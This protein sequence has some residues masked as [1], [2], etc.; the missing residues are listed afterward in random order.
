MRA[1]SAL[2]SAGVSRIS[3]PNAFIRT[4]GEC[5]I[6][7][8]SSKATRVVSVSGGHLSQLAVNRETRPGPARSYS[9]PSAVIS[10]RIGWRRRSG[11]AV[12]TALARMSAKAGAAADCRP[13][14][15]MVML[16]RT[17]GGPASEISG[18]KIDPDLRL[19]QRLEIERP[20]FSRRRRGVRL[21]HSG[22]KQ[23]SSQHSAISIRLP[24]VVSGRIHPIFAILIRSE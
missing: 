24:A 19:V 21:E 11:K 13:L 12:L 23:R 6:S 5:A 16:S 18:E 10:R 17:G 15:R 20:D 8:S 4:C 7:R 14:N 9:R 22:E 3:N 1:P 2:R